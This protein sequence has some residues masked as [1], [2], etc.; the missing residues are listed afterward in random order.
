[1]QQLIGLYKDAGMSLHK[2]A[3]SYKEVL[4]GCL[5]RKSL[6]VLI[7]S[8][9]RHRIPELLWLRLLAWFGSPIHTALHTAKI[10][11]RNQYNGLGGNVEHYSKAV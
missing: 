2:L 11:K 7:S 4:E 8:N 10:P 9:L 1:M 5:S 6:L 3:F